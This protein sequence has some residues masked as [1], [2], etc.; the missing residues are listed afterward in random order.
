MHK[1]FGVG[2]PTE[3]IHS[4]GEIASHLS[5]SNFLFREMHLA[6]RTL[7]SVEQTATAITPAKELGT[8]QQVL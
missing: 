3:E 2:G 6:L 4:V 1:C 7:C 8:Q 5:N